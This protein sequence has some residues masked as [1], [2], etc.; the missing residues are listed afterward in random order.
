AEKSGERSLLTQVVVPAVV[1]TKVSEHKLFVRVSVFTPFEDL[2]GAVEHSTELVL[3][4]VGKKVGTARANTEVVGV[5]LATGYS[6][7]VLLAVYL[8]FVSGRLAVHR[9][10]PERR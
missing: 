10:K 5:L 3:A 4:T 1:R 8:L 7:L 2:A 6:F 9:I